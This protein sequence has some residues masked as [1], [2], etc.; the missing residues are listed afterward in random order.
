MVMNTESRRSNSFALG[1]TVLG[2]LLRLAP[3]PPNFAP[4]GATGLFSGSRLSGWQ[5]YVVPLIAMLITDPI[6]S[7]MEGHYPAY[8][9]MTVAIYASL[10]VYVFLG[11]T[12][13]RGTSAPV[14]IALVS[15][16]GSTQ[17]FLITN[18]FFWFGSEVEYPHTF[19]GLV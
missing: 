13:L 19:A 6:R 17:F 4:I 16:L 2:A 15:V 10:I 12:L 14:R 1:L 5:A 8:S 3:H 7:A 11:R 9:A 18:F